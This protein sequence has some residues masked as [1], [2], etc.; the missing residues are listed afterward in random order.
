MLRL[1]QCHSVFDAARL[2]RLF[3]SR[4]NLEVEVDYEYFPFCNSFLSSVLLPWNYI[5]VLVPWT[6]DSL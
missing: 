2:E 4:H 6:L 1:V 5:L 3:D